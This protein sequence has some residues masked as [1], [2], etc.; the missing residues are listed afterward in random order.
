MSTVLIKPEI[1]T[2]DRKQ[3]LYMMIAQQKTTRDF[4]CSVSEFMNSIDVFPYINSP[5]YVNEFGVLTR[6]YREITSCSRDDTY[7]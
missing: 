4:T 3:I 2:G 7:Q 6:V 5:D 1:S